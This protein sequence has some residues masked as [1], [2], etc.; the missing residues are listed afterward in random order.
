MNPIQA[1]TEDV[2]CQQIEQNSWEFQPGQLETHPWKYE[3]L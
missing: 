2:Y 3:Y 1:E